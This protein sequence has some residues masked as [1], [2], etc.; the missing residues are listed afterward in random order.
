MKR[1]L[2]LGLLLSVLFTAMPLFA[3]GAGVGD[4]Y[5]AAIADMQSLG[6]LYAREQAVNEAE[7]LYPGDEYLTDAD[8]KNAREK[9]L[10]VLLAAEYCNEYIA[11][12]QELLVLEWEEYGVILAA[13]NAESQARALADMAYP[14]VST[15]Y[16]A[17]LPVIGQLEERVRVSETFLESVKKASQKSGYST[18]KRALDDSKMY[19]TNDK[20]IPDHPATVEAQALMAEIERE[21][22]VMRADATAFLLAVEGMS[23]SNIYEALMQVYPYYLKTDST[24]SGVSEVYEMYNEELQSYNGRVSDI[25]AFVRG[26]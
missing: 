25:N 21:L 23:G 1:L 18:V 5:V 17:I 9:A 13:V 15:A 7:Q 14:G 26:E 3:L 4:E 6:S 12:A 2:A 24:V 11:T 22:S 8:L 20:L 16:N 19:L 10:A